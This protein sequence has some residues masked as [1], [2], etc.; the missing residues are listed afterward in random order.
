MIR[1]DIIPTH[2][3]FRGFGGVILLSLCL[4]LT[5]FG[6][7][8][9]AT[10]QPVEGPTTLIE[11]QVFDHI[12]AGVKDVTV[13]ARRPAA[14]GAE[15][16]DLA[17]T[18][19]DDMG[20]F[21]LLLPGKVTGKV[22]VAF[23]KAGFTEVTREVEFDPDPD[24]EFPPFVDALLGGA[25]KLTGTVRDFHTE[26]P[27]AAA[28]VRVEFGYDKRET[29]T[30]EDGTFTVAELPPGQARVT[31]ETERYGREQR[32][33]ES[34]AEAEPLDVALKPER[35]VHLRTVDGDDK[36]VGRVGVECVAEEQKDYRSLATDAAGQLTIHNVHYDTRKLVLRLSHQSYISSEDFDR[37]IELAS[38][39]IESTHTLVL[40]QAGSIAG[41]IIDRSE[42]RPVNGARVTAGDYAFGRNP[43]DFTGFDGT[44][45]INGVPPG[46]QAVTVFARGYAPEL[47]EVEVA[48]GQVADLEVKLDPPSLVGGTVADADGK[49]LTGVHVMSVKWRGHETLTLQSLTGAD[50]RFVIPDAPTDEFLISLIH[51]GHEPLLERPVR[52][53]KTDYRFAMTPGGPD[54]MPGATVKVGDD[55]PPFELTTLDGRTLKLADLKGKTVLL[56]FWATWCGPCVAEMPNVKKIH[57]ALGQRDDFVMI[58]ISLDTDQKALQ[59]FIKDQKIGWAQVYGPKS[60]AE[61]ASRDYGAFAIPATFL[62]GPDGKIKSTDLRGPGMKDQVAKLVGK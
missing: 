33:V 56:D 21:T 60:G 9:P 34:V 58:G 40:E 42:Q 15:P 26:K 62:I 37:E 50:G 4:D 31:V 51:P 13:I 54:G 18:T 61:K 41:R 25:G 32:E 3:L 36:P 44:Y 6:L 2:R 52:A 7:G 49:P 23:T 16:A 22:V 1:T 11:G 27:V 39:A 43:R 20:D 17:T 10:S 46:R 57:D 38:D 45:R 35:I 14:K 12:G 53:P 59:R 28:T 5:A 55:A 47:A 24:D 19:T 29:Q 8:D 48:A 30:A